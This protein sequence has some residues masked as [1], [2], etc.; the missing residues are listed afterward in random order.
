MH[1]NDDGLIKN[2][3]INFEYADKWLQSL[4]DSY[5]I[6]DV[7]KDKKEIRLIF[8]VHNCDE[9]LMRKKFKELISKYSFYVAIINFAMNWNPPVASKLNLKEQLIMFYDY[10]PVLWLMKTGI[11]KVFD[12][13]IEK[14]LLACVG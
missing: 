10:L 6:S 3:N 2:G 9:F 14:R 11:T 1:F 5:D 7:I 12:K 4:K 8:E 13:I